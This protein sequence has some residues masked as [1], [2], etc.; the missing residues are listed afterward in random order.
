MMKNTFRKKWKIQQVI[1]I[2]Y[3]KN[4]NLFLQIKEKIKDNIQIKNGRIN[5]LK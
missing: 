2:H 3:T 4:S 1:F 5:L